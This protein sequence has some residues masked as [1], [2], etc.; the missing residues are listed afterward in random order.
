MAK[1]MD[2]YTNRIDDRRFE[3]WDRMIS[4]NDNSKKVSIILTVGC[5]V[6]L[7]LLGS[8]FLIDMGKPIPSKYDFG[9]NISYDPASSIYFI[10]Y[11]NP[12]QTTTNLNVDIKVPYSTSYSS[13]YSTVYTTTTSSFPTNISYKPYNKDME[14][15]VTVTLIKPAGNYTCFFSNTPSDDEKLYNGVTKYTDE[16]DRYLTKGNT[17]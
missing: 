13:A 2:N 16:I 15:V 11:T 8:S 10:D 7:L 1:H 3:K 17:S 12:N 4:S 14:H 5:I 9:L 6:S